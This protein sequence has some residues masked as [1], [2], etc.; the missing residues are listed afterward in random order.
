MRLKLLL[1]PLVALAGVLG[2]SSYATAAHVPV[3]RTISV[4]G[5]GSGVAAN[6]YFPNA[7]TIHEDDTIHFANTYDEPHTVTYVPPATDKPELIIPN[8]L[9]G[10]GQIFNPK[11]ENPSNTGAGATAFDPHAY[12]NSG[13]M[14]KD[15]TADVTFD[16][17]GSF[18]FLC[19]FHPG[20]ELQVSVVSETVAIASQADLDKK[21]AAARD[22]L[23]AGGKA[24]AAG[25][26]LTKTTDA[27]GTSTW[28]AQAGGGAG[29]ADVVQFL[30]V[31]SLSIK[32]GDT[33]HWSNPTF[34][35]HTV[36]FTSG[37]E[38]PDLIATIPNPKG[39]PPSFD[40]FS[41]AALFPAGGKT[42]DGTGLAHSGI[43]DASGEFPAGTEYSLTFTKPGTYNYICILHD[44]Q[45]MKSTIVVSD[46]AAAPTTSVKPPS[47]G[48][49][50]MAGAQR[51]TWLPALLILGIAGLA[52]VVAGARATVKH[53][54]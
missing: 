5:G 6:D 47:T 32:T 7:I 9:G 33:V 17:T 35:P 26:Q 27:G 41:P 14:F 4:G 28:F 15:A 29:Q 50:G 3:T 43:F 19:L 23:I 30:P 24:I 40:T 11:A 31:G 38:E 54:A 21:G 12:F 18:K 13:F 42:Y 8:P 34:T 25:Y 20:M 45:G 48:T 49:G 46:R 53:E 2:V 44:D 10:P 36:T 39:T 37:G 52:L 22:A 51:G 1:I 16:T